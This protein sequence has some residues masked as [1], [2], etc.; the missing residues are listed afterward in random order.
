MRHKRL[1]CRGGESFTY[2]SSSTGS[3]EMSLLV[4]DGAPSQP[5]GGLKPPIWFAVLPHLIGKEEKE[6]INA[7]PISSHKPP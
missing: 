4:E 6:I 1:V 5:T 2:T 3:C 7:N